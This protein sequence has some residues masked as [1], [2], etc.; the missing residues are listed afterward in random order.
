MR[1][2]V[3]LLLLAVVI[4]AK[5]PPTLSASYFQAFGETFSLPNGKQE[6]INGQL[7]YE[8]SKNRERIDRVN[9][10]F[11]KFCSS[12]LPNV[13][14]PCTQTTVHDRR[15]IIYPQRRQCCF[16]C[17]SAHGCGILK[18][19]WL[20]GANYMGMETIDG[21]AYDK[22][23]KK[24]GEDNYWWATTDNDQIPRR[25]QEG[26]SHVFDFVVSSFENI[27]FPDTLFEIPTYCTSSCPLSSI[28]G[29]FR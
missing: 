10:Q 21:T 23:E 24:G 18:T 15:Y 2:S 6:K 17:D 12:V 20:D 3:S 7:F 11:D 26:D 1:V 9:G 5:D 25:L 8:A 19:T 22:W 14:T 13:S 28:C 29:Q 16:C 27:T 4:L